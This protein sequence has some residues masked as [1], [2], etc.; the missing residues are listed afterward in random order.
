MKKWDKYYYRD[1]FWKIQVAIWGDFPEWDKLCVKLWII[2]N[3]PSLSQ[4]KKADSTYYSYKSNE[5]HTRSKTLKNDN[6]S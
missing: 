6:I 3:N 2:V 1:R 4:R 5:K